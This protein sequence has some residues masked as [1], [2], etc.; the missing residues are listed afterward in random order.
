MENLTEMMRQATAAERE[1]RA[2]HGGRT[3]AQILKDN[4]FLSDCVRFNPFTRAHENLTAQMRLYS[5]SADLAE[6][7]K[8][9]AKA[10]EG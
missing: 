3:K 5:L 8:R 10:K 2:E 9:E 7:L 1:E 4:A 6:H